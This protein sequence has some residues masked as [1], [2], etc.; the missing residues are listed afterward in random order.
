[1]KIKDTMIISLLKIMF[2]KEN[3]VQLFVKRHVP[4]FKAYI[5]F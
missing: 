1:M 5:S 2:K 4:T 3:Y